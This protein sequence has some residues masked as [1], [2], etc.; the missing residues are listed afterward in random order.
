M[1]F[2]L[3]VLLA[4]T[5]LAYAKNYDH[6]DATPD[7]VRKWYASVMMPDHPEVSCCGEADAYWADSFEVEGDHYVAI[8]TDER[9]IPGRYDLPVGTK[10]VIPNEK[11]PDGHYG[12]PTGHGVVFM[13]T[14]QSVYCYFPT[15]GV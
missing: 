15:G 14:T 4:L 8:I 2:A 1:R 9:K 7:D 13:S 6:D 5:S 12:N 10:V 11:L 3:A